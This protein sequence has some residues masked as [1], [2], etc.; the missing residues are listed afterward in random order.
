[1][2]DA[3]TAVPPTWKDLT[4]SVHI[5]DC[6]GRMAAA[7]GDT[8]QAEDVRWAAQTALRQLYIAGGP[9]HPGIDGHPALPVIREW[10]RRHRGADLDQ[11]SLAGLGC[12]IRDQRYPLTPDELA[13]LPLTEVAL[14]LRSVAPA[15]G[16]VISP[17]MGGR[18]RMSVKEANAKAMQLAERQKRKFFLLSERE[19]AKAIGCSWKTWSKTELYQTAKK[20]RDIL[21]KR[22]GS[23][24]TAGPPPAVSLTDSL[25]Q[26]LTDEQRKDDRS[27]KVRSRSRL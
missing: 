23:S 6:L 10:I 5:W 19:Q 7:V 24:T 13:A 26:R 14:I 17:Q 11:L 15:E 3:S 4:H 16:S 9:E 2:Y 12:W 25:L 18:R 22:A 21:A 20:Q 8:P 27:D 1:M